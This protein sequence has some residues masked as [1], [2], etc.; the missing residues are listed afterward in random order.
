M[1]ALSDGF[2]QALENMAVWGP[3]LLLGLLILLLGYVLAKVL[4]KA[5]VKLARSLGLDRPVDHLN[6]EREGPTLPESRRPSYFVGVGV[7]WLIILFALVGFFS[8]LELG[9]VAE[10][11]SRLLGRFGDGLPNAIGALVLLGIGWLL[12]TVL[13]GLVVKGLDGLQIDAR[14]AEKGM[15]KPDK[16]ERRPVSRIG[17]IIVYGLVLLLFAQSALE[18]LGLELFAG[19]IQRGFNSFVDF[20]PNLV[21]AAVILGIAF[22]LATLLRPVILSLLDSLGINKYGSYI[23]LSET[24]SATDAQGAPLTLSG[25]LA[26][27]AYWAILLFALPAALDQLGLEPIVTPLRNIWNTIL[28]S[29]PNILAAFLIILAG[30]VIARVVGPIVQRMLEGIGFD[31]ILGK[32][33][34]SKYQES[35]ER[36]DESARPSRILTNVLLIVIGL[37]LAQEVMDTLGMEYLA[38]MIAG[39]VAY[40]P[41]ILVAVVILGFALYL[42]QWVGDLVRKSTSGLDNWNSKIV[43]TVAQVAVIVFGVTMALGQLHVGGQV[44]EA[45]VL[46]LIAGFALALA[47]SLG[48]GAK[49]LVERYLERKFDAE[50]A[51]ASSPELPEG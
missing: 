19:S 41:N 38:T 49:P 40:L 36:G 22:I 48:L 8:A 20:I 1:E 24:E 23:G 50:K 12:A 13:K 3:R 30:W 6:A 37:V 21:S 17:G 44:V 25:V 51:A 35:V 27:V 39:I 15:E 26:N 33:G 46:L 4:Q 10:P 14:L 42:G 43:G 29:I 28:N 34:L 9:M 45:S 16:A 31:S 7:F 11:F 32:I 2:S 5:T 18:L 47:I